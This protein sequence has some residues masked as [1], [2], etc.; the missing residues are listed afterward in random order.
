MKR[1][2]TTLAVLTFMVGVLF[3]SPAFAGR[4][5]NRQ[6]RQHN[7]IDQ[8]VSS[9]ELTRRET[10]SL[11]RE[12]KAFQGLKKQFWQDGHLTPKEHIRL[13]NAQDRS[14]DHIYRLKHNN[15]EN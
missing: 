10:A 14:S 3:S 15:R 4:V 1:L 7:R 12:Q 11:V 9:G 8:G 13:E 5:A 2:I 6:I